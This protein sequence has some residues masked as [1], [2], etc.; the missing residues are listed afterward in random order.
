MDK[1]DIKL[2]KMFG[3]Y[4]VAGPSKAANIGGVDVTP[5]VLS[6]T[7]LDSINTNDLDGPGSDTLT[8]QSVGGTG[9]SFVPPIKFNAKIGSRGSGNMPGG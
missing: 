5:Q 8:D 4:K 1:L 2:W 7:E 6:I 9:P 3:I